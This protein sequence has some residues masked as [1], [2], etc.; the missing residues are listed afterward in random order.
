VSGHPGSFEVIS[1]NASGRATVWRARCGRHRQWDGPTYE[2]VED[3]WR[4]HVHA[5]TGTMPAPM[6]D[7]TGRETPR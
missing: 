7:K 1:R 6:G 3:E 5:E 4:R 2:A